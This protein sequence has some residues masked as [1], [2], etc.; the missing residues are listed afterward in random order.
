M[1][2][3][4]LCLLALLLL[5][6]CTE[7]PARVSAEELA[8]LRARYPYS[9]EVAH[10]LHTPDETLCPDFQTY[11]SYFNEPYSDPSA[12]TL[13]VI[14]LTGD[15]F[16]NGT[17]RMRAKAEQILW[18]DDLTAGEEFYLNFGLHADDGMYEIFQKGARLVCFLKTQPNSDSLFVSKDRTWYLTE[19]N[20]V[21]SIFSV[22]GLDETSGLYLDAFAELVTDTMK[23]LAK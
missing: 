1:K 14:D 11:L 5:C 2:K 23:Q 3:I 6:G 10:P 4:L 18:G 16:L 8:A 19:D 22:R 20:V 13:A 9:D 15:R 17:P 21:L 12:Y 7:D